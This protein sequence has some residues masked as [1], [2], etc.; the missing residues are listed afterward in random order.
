MSNALH[1]PDDT[2]LFDGSD[3]FADDSESPDERRARIL[4]E[5]DLN[6]IGALREL[7]KRSGLSQDA[8][9]KRMGLTQPAL[10]AF[11]SQGNDPKLS[12]IRRYA[13]ALGA[14]VNHSAALDLDSDTSWRG[15]KV[16]SLDAHRSR[17]VV[18]RGGWG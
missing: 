14:I 13:H 2:H 3:P 7:R 8:L 15:H 10:A 11:E 16:V 12:T 6:L 5:N 17:R 18:A 9:A 4:M 1:L